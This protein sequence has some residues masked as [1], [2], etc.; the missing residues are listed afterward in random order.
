MC[1]YDNLTHMKFNFYTVAAFLFLALAARAQTTAF[2]YQGQLNSSNNAVTGTYDFRFRIFDANSNVVAGPLTNAPVGVTNGLF[3]VALDFGASVFNGSSRSLEIAVRGYGDTNAYTALSP[4]QTLTSVPYAIQSLNALN[5]VALTAPLQATNLAGTIPN[6]LL[7]PNVAVLTNNV[8]FSGGVTATNFTGN[9]YGLSNVPGTSLVGI[10]TGNGSGL[11]SVPATSLIGT[12]PDA[13]LSANVALQSN[14]NLNFAGAVSATNFT[15]AGH[16]LTN[17][18]GAFFWVTVAANTQAQPN[19]GYICNNGV[20][21]V[22]ITLPSSPSAGDVYKVAG[23]GAGG[24]IIAQNANQMIAAG[25][26]SAAVFQSWKAG[27]SALNWSAIASSADGTKLVA[28]VN[29]G[30]IWT[31]ANSGATW[32][33]QN[34]S[35][36]SGSRYWS[37]VASSSDGTHLVA[38]VGYTIYTANQPGA[39]YTSTD[40]GV[41]WASHT[42]SPLSSSM[43][44]SSVASSADGTKLVAAV[45]SGQIYIS[46]NSGSSW[47]AQGPNGLLWISV[48]SSSD[49][50]KL[51]AVENNGQIYTSSNSGTLWTQRV[52]GTTNWVAVASSTDGSRLVATASGGQISIST[53]SGVTWV[54]QSSPVTGTITSVAS[55]SDGSRLAVTAGG[56]GA[57]GNIFASSDSGATWTQLAGAPT[58]SW[59]D[60]ASSADGSQLAAAVYGGN[61]YVSSQ[62]STTTGAAGYLIGPQHS[63]IELIYAGN[64]LFLPLSHEGTIRAY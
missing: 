52:S 48:A 38:A 60:I 55:S 10:I 8:I 35:S 26:L 45:R 37:S 9:G 63:A 53:D 4:W 7:S 59:A 57:S 50:T 40:S 6:S 56:S 51:V 19:V 24:W 47:T 62:S 20:A 5:A 32:T 3:T 36:G 21:P 14:P 41:T 34:G 22:T 27:A 1:G 28:A 46:S 49:G 18:P 15:G 12:I 13:R 30:Y 58:V 2:T 39:I 29:N 17:V 54:A 44:W 16:G 42:S 43:N 61:I 11:S 64:N 33:Q 23:V 31:S 25:N